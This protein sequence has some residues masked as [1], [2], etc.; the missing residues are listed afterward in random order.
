MLHDVDPVQLPPPPRLFDHVTWITP[1]LSEADPLISNELLLVLKVGFDVGELI[2]TEG[3]VV[4][5]GAAAAPIPEGSTMTPL[6]A[7]STSPNP[8][9]M[10][11]RVTDFPSALKTAWAE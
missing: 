6:A 9:S 2:V 1:T 4:S 7:P 11:V 10:K 3:S 8:P 5:G